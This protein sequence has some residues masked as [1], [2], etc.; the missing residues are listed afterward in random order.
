MRYFTL[1]CKIT[2]QTLLVNLCQDIFLNYLKLQLGFEDSYARGKKNERE[3]ERE[4]QTE[5]TFSL[6]LLNA[7]GQL[8]ELAS[9]ATALNMIKCIHYSFSYFLSSC[10]KISY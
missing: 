8:F 9:L 6:T 10:R 1:I 2:K 5:H 4:Q 3:R 7:D